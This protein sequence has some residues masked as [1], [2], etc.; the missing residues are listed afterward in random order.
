MPL[1]GYKLH[2]KSFQDSTNLNLS[3][4]TIAVAPPVVVVAENHRKRQRLESNEQNIS[5][6][7]TTTSI[8]MVEQVDE[9]SRTK[10]SKP[11]FTENQVSKPCISQSKPKS[12][13]PPVIQPTPPI[14]LAPVI[15]NDMDSESPPSLPSTSGRIKELKSKTPAWKAQAPAPKGDVQGNVFHPD[16]MQNDDLQL[17][18][19]CRETPHSIRFR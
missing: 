13:P 11:N 6:E 8:P 9:Q 5:S 2:R 12:P 15:E 3:A 17:V 1:V 4:S 7:S 19:F 10:K 18:L 14:P 16:R